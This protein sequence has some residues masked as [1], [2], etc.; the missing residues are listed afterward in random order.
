MSI[1]WGRLSSPGENGEIMA[2]DINAKFQLLREEVL[3]S[4]YSSQKNL[5]V[6]TDAPGL[7]LWLH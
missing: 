3:Q 4:L 6:H 5:G 1:E 2:E 7:K